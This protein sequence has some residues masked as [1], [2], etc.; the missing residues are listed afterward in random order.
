VEL[1]NRN[2][3]YYI[4]IQSHWLIADKNWRLKYWIFIY[5]Y[6]RDGYTPTTVHCFITSGLGWPAQQVLSEKPICYQLIARS[7][8]L[9][10]EIKKHINEHRRKRRTSVQRKTSRISAVFNP[11]IL[12]SYAYTYLNIRL[13]VTWQPLSTIW[14]KQRVIRFEFLRFYNNKTKKRNWF[15]NEG[16]IRTR[17]LTYRLFTSRRLS[18]RT[19]AQDFTEQNQDKNQILSA[20]STYIQVF[21][22]KKSRN[23]Q[24]N[25]VIG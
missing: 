19:R 21:C 5:A 9:I 18:Y 25:Q 3:Y 17:S 20:I 15:Y 8:F 7:K 14:N 13:I 12:L 1:D 4:H 24:R 22:T 16:T 11:V 6:N 10:S 2:I 23:W